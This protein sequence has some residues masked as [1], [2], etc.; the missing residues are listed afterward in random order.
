MSDIRG[1]FR[2]LGADSG[3][4]IIVARAPSV[5]QTIR[6]LE[7]AAK[8]NAADVLMRSVKCIDDLKQRSTL[9]PNAMFECLD[10]HK[11]NADHSDQP[12]LVVLAG[13][14][15]TIA[16]KI[17]ALYLAVHD[18]GNKKLREELSFLAVKVVDQPMDIVQV[19]VESARYN[20]REDIHR[21]F[22]DMDQIISVCRIIC[23]AAYK[24]DFNLRTQPFKKFAPQHYLPT[25]IDSKVFDKVEKIRPNGKPTVPSNLTGNN[26]RLMEIGRALAQISVDYLDTFI[27]NSEA[28]P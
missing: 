2:G 18:T 20:V 5:V 9:W 10:G 4:G 24:A 27:D 1:S 14:H 13:N 19:L 8:P 15:R 7:N 17:E 21:P 11:P 28:S 23:S 26:R 22:G 3:H 25:L 12:A 6:Y 16:A